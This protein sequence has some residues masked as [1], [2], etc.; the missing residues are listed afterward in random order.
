MA[1]ASCP[2]L[3]REW[4]IER[5]LKR[6][7]QANRFREKQPNAK[8]RTCPIGGIGWVE[9]ERSLPNHGHDAHA[10][11][12]IA[13][14][15]VIL[16]SPPKNPMIPRDRE[17]IDVQSAGVRCRSQ[18]ARQG[19]AK[20]PYA[21]AIPAGTSTVEFETSPSAKRDGRVRRHCVPGARRASGTRDSSQAL[22]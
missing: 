3:S 13:F 10:T 14:I 18:V 7:D 11:S 5:V 17:R 8:E 9:A 12:A 20:P 2:W 16:L 1:R 21:G 4:K 15:P 22:S 19:S 6:K